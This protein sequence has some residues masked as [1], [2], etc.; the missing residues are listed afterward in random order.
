MY[1]MNEKMLFGR[2]QNVSTYPTAGQVDT[3]LG[4]VNKSVKYPF[5]E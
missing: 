5:N 1:K 4:Y 3:A 2:R